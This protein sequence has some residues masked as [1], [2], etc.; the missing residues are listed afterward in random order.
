ME[1]IENANVGEIKANTAL[2]VVKEVVTAAPAIVT[3][4]FI[5]LFMAFFMLIYGRTLLRQFLR[6]IPSFG[7][8]RVVIEAVRDIQ[9]SLYR[10]LSTITAVNIGL[11]VAVGTVLA[12]LG[13]E[14]AFLWGVFA[15]LMNFAP[16]L[17]PMISVACIG[18]VGFL[19]FDSCNTH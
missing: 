2:S 4:L 6:Q 9:A 8:K 3:Q 14:D 7:D 13:M 18:L 11:G 15:A 12:L 10:Y 16:Y 1:V 5:A 19:Q 17:G